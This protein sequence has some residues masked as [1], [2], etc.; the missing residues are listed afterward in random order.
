ML[1]TIVGN[2]VPKQGRLNEGVERDLVVFLLGGEL[3]GVSIKQ[4]R[5]IIPL[6][7][8]TRVP[9]TPKYILGV[10]NLRGR[11]IPVIDLRSRLGLPQ[12]KSQGKKNIAVVDLEQY[13]VGMLVDGVSEVLQ[14]GDDAVE[15]PPPEAIGS[16][17][18]CIVGV[19]KHSGRLIILLDL[20]Q[21]LS[22]K[23]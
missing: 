8:I 21:V 14:I 20:P 13:T 3:Y 23:D 2:T 15:P 4:V 5:E 18:D 11:V 10:I 22:R 16:G 6:Q 17:G 1:A 7:P 19:A 12:D 9:R